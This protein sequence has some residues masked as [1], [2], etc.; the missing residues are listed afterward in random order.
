MPL[1]AGELNMR[2][3]KTHRA[4]TR[5]PLLFLV[6]G[7]L[8]LLTSS[9]ISTIGAACNPQEA[10]DAA[11][12]NAR[13]LELYGSGKY[14]DAIKSYKE[15]IRLKQDYAEAHSNL[16]DAYFQ[17]KEYKKA[18][19]ECKQVLRY[20]PGSSAAYNNIGTAYRKLGEHKKAIE[21]YKEAIRRN[22]KTT[23][24][25]FNLGATYVGQS[26]Y[27]GALEQYRI[28][29]TIDPQVAEKLY[30]LIY[31]P[32]AT[33][34]DGSGVRL[35]VIATDSQGIPSND[36]SE[37]DFQIFEDGQ[38]QTISS[39]SKSQFPLVYTL[40]ID[41]S[42]SI[43]P[44]FKQA[45]GVSKTLIE[46]NL[47]NDETLLVRFISSDK[48]EKV[49]EFTSD[50]KALNDGVKDLYIDYGKSA[51]LD[52]VYLSAQAV[53]QYKVTN[54]SY[55]RRAVI[56]VT[57][58]DE[59]ASYYTMDNLLKL[60]HEIDVQVFVVSL[61]KESKSGKKLN[62]EPEKG[63]VDLLTKLAKETGGHAFFPKSAAE[64]ETAIK[65]LTSMIR[66][67]YLITYKPVE[68]VLAESYRKV[69]VDIVDKPGRDKRSVVTR[70]GY[71][72][73]KQ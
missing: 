32:M 57:D 72:V 36:L 60:L 39:F 14:E 40:A 6:I 19:E 4:W 12:Y 50:K 21:A 41:A 20:D 49:Q 55:L 5:L 15:A 66:T 59:R 37:E 18:I 43:A 17:L 24:T 65:L 31:K 61:Q 47:P 25:Y 10:N 16:A 13:G 2:I 11:A 33:V 53:A 73:P 45:I 70:S 71:I 42:G 69:N 28:L 22:P 27:E 44:A 58:G 68:S 56:L 64:L 67:Q 63:A 29:K 52:A 46:N 9:G 54:G 3:P 7:P 8:S 30:V 48:I 38:P 62:E 35:N 23:L 51:I 1:L 34:F 26:D